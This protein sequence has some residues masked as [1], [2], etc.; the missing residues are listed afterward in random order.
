MPMKEKSKGF[1][2]KL[3]G[4]PP[5]KRVENHEKRNLCLGRGTRVFE[6]KKG[7]LTSGWYVGLS[8][9]CVLFVV[10]VYVVNVVYKRWDK[11]I[12]F[13]CMHL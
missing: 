11:R 8:F 12:L 1:G 13:C 9:C 4:G 7:L 10:S 5:R 3:R 6:K 2:L